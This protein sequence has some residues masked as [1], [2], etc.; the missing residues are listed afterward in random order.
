[1]GRHVW[2]AAA[3]SL[4]LWTVIV[5]TLR[6][7]VAELLAVLLLALAV[8]LGTVLAA[9]RRRGRSRDLASTVTDSPV[10]KGR[11]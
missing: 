8:A 11:A 1:M 6:P 10:D 2:P 3:A 5:A 4:V 9:S 7:G